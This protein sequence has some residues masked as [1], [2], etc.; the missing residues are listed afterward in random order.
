MVRDFTHLRAGRPAAFAWK[1]QDLHPSGAIGDA[2][3][4]TAEAGRA[5]LDH[6]AAAFIALLHDVDAFELDGSGQA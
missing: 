2:R 5:A 1:A 3:I 4:G 6:A